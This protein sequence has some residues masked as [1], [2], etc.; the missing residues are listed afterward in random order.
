MIK[1]SSSLLEGN[2]RR[3][4]LDQLYKSFSL[5]SAPTGKCTS[6][7]CTGMRP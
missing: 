3:N 7:S 5:A 6:L 4:G 2:D 1:E